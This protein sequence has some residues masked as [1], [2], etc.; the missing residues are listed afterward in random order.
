LEP[1][2]PQYTALVGI[3]LP[4]RLPFSVRTHDGETLSGYLTRPSGTPPWPAVLL[5][6]GGPW[7]RDRAGFDASAQWLA[8]LGAL[9]VQV[10]FRGSTGRGRRFLDAGNGEWGGLMQSDLADTLEHV[11]HEGLALGDRIAVMGDSY[12]GYAALMAAVWEGPPIRCAVATSAPTDLV[13]FLSWT[14]SSRPVVGGVY[15]RRIGD[16]RTEG[17]RLARRSPLA[18]AARLRV[19]VLLAHGARDARVPVNQT[20]RFIE[21]LRESGHQPEVMILHDEGHRIHQPTNRRTWLDR[22]ARFL[23]AHL[24]LP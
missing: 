14:R 21:A 1:A 24:D 5:V 22:V 8:S 15:R 10:N 18:R 19:P 11:I 7:L 23:Q 13:E 16:E 4:P 3:R 6:H 12:G 2:L 20:R 9:V 17:E